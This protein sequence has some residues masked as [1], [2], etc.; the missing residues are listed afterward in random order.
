MVAGARSWGAGDAAAGRP[1]LFFLSSMA[2]RSSSTFAPPRRHAD[3][4]HRAHLPVGGRQDP[5]DVIP[6]SETARLVVD[7]IGL[8]GAARPI[9]S[10]SATG[11]TIG[12]NDGVISGVAEGG[13]QADGRLCADIC[14]R[15]CRRRF[16]EDT[17]YFQ[18]ARYR[19]PD[20]EFR[21]LPAGRSTCAPSA[22]TRT[23]TCASPRELRRRISDIPGNRGRASAAGGQLRRPSTPISTAPAAAQLGLNANN[24]VATNVNVSLSFVGAG[25]TEFL[26]R[27]EIGHSLLSCGADAREPQS[28]R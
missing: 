22:M 23:M 2:G 17:F 21:G 6:A 13:P 24:T 7:N 3:R 26:D 20:P 9:I 5:P 25:D 4:G 12:V 15:C 16:P 1:R 10:R 18:A 19:Y 8:P 11:S 14:A 27:S 28:A